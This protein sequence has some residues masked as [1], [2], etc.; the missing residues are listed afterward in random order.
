MSDHLTHVDAML[1]PA[2]G[3]PPKIVS[4]MTSR[5]DTG[6][7]SPTRLPHPEVHMDF[8]A[9]TLGPDAWKFVLVEAL[10]GMTKKFANPY[11]L[12]YPTVSRDSMAF[13]INKCIQEFQGLAFREEYAWR[14]NVV[15]SKYCPK[16][17]D[18][19]PFSSLQEVAISDF[20]VLKNYLMTHGLPKA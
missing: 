14:G 3:R 5:A 2:D 4:L 13:P 6:Q 16:G 12:F 8:V 9:D 10:D 7:A 17:P 1:I 19:H 18:D 11:I 15:V 20:P